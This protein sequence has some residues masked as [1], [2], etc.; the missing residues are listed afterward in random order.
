MVKYTKSLQSI[1][2]SSDSDS[3]Y[4][5]MVSFILNLFN[6]YLEHVIT[7]TTTPWLVALGDYI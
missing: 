7:T 1:Y 3:T 4:N 6:Q 5:Q 2:D